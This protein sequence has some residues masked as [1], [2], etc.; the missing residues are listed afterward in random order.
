MTESTSKQIEVVFRKHNHYWLDAGLVG[1]CV[2]L[3]K[4]PNASKLMTLSDDEL[5][6]KGTEKEIKEALENAKDLLVKSYYDVSTENQ[7]SGKN[8]YNFYYDSVNKEFV[9]FAKRSPVGLAKY[10]FAEA[11]HPKGKKINWVGKNSGVLPSAYASLQFDLDKFRE[12]KD[13][14]TK[15]NSLLIDGPNTSEPNMTIDLSDKKTKG[16]RCFLCGEES[17]NLKEINGTVYPF[18]TGS[19]GEFSF[20]SMVGKPEKV[21]WKCSLLGK[22]VPVTAFY[23]C[24]EI[25]KINRIF[26][27]LPYSTSLKT[28]K[29][30]YYGLQLAYFEDPNY[31]RNFD[32]LL[33]NSS[34]FKKPFETL[35]SFLYTVFRKMSASVPSQQFNPS[36]INTLLGSLA[37]DFLNSTPLE[38]AI[39]QAHKSKS[40]TIGENVW[41]F[42]DSVY[43][44]RL[45]AYLE[46][47]SINLK[48]V[49]SIL[50]DRTQQEKDNQTIVRNQVCERI[51]KKQSI[52][53]IVV[54]FISR[55][56]N[57][58][59][60]YVAPL[61]DF[62]FAYESII[63]T[64][65]GSMKKEDQ[66]VAV[67]LGK[68][69]GWITVALQKR[70]KKNPDKSSLYALRRV[71]KKT[72]FL[73]E[74]NRLQFK[75]NLAVPPE[76]Y[77]G[78]L[79]DENFLEFK[80]FCSL[81]AFNSFGAAMANEK[82][83]VIDMTKGE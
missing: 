3:E 12:E 10:I 33:G 78:S 82:E 49:M 13:I 75:Y 35:F 55:P 64:K 63:R 21:C 24:P 19:S 77:G 65:G 45:V 61:V 32:S 66:D 48:E 76:I 17:D 8:G 14:T 28:M 38:F 68:R 22:F 67:M 6:L 69:I 43:F 81:A 62:V 70:D 44:F 46:L 42:Q 34:T 11:P 80:N 83:K 15:S 60:R 74:L 29:D 71:R 40:A 51:L 72:D 4:V 16:T 7:Q 27:F 30:A 56:D 37:G 52:L 50:V 9:Q 53:K 39:F 26:A 31:Y 54:S 59:L 57:K 58:S 5:V 25:K 18:I 47:K 73:N 36:D 79:T 2:L 20:N 23:M 1:L 41:I